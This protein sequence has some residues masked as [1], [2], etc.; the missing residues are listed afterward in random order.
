MKLRLCG[1]GFKAAVDAA[2]PVSTPGP[3]GILGPPSCFFHFEVGR[4][5]AVLYFR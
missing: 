5:V 1:R 4:N 3:T 2:A